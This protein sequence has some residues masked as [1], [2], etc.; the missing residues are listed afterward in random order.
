MKNP[1]GGRDLAEDVFGALNRCCSWNSTDDWK[2]P[3]KF[4][5]LMTDAPAHGLVPSCSQHIMNADNF[6]TVHPSGLTATKVAEIMMLQGIDLFFCSFN[7][8]ATADTE[9][10]LSKAL[11][12]LPSNMD[13]RDVTSIP[14]VPTKQPLSSGIPILSH[15]KCQHIIFILDESSSM[16]REWNG[17]VV[18]YQNFLKERLQNQ[19]TADLVSVVQFNQSARVT[20][21][22]QWIS[23]APQN[24]GYRGGNTCYTPAAEQGCQLALSTPSS[25]S[26]VV[27]F[28][29]D[30][31]AD[32]RDAEYTA[33][34][35]K[36]TTEKVRIHDGNDISLH[37]IAFGPG[38]DQRQ[39]LNIMHSSSNGRIHSSANAS[40]LSDIFIEIAKTTSDVA[41]ILEA[42]IGRRI[43]EAVSDKV[44]LE[45][46]G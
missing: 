28:M 18:A 12:N 36:R 30:G 33:S 34:I 11:L 13:G 32:E 20:V 37:V 42:E 40:Q 15:G 23:D 3:A 16:H 9:A 29:S 39:L 46:L 24:L 17:V 4:I 31:L 45:Y 5:I 26:P 41:A 10:C 21:H 38:M 14:M 8:E 2:A 19:C 6:P 25:H 22:Q 1:S 27:I 43:S 35:F 7:P 44:S